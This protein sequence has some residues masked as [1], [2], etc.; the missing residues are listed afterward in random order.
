MWE[1]VPQPCPLLLPL[2]GSNCCSCGG[3]LHIH[4]HREPS[5][6]VGFLLHLPKARQ[7]YDT[8]SWVKMVAAVLGHSN[9][10]GG[11]QDCWDL[12]EFAM[13]MSKERQVGS[14]LL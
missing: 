9:N 11:A 1:W 12:G 7:L 8:M 14:N 4:I 6:T 10:F 2:S 3:P 13:L 5:E